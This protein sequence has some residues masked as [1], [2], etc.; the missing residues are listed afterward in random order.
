MRDTIWSSNVAQAELDSLRVQAAM[1][2]DPG[3]GYW[4]GRKSVYYADFIWERNISQAS[5]VD[6]ANGPD[7]RRVVL[8]V[9]RDGATR[10]YTY[11]TYIR[12]ARATIDGVASE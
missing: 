5:L 8:G 9:R 6:S 4:T 1:G 7:L 12:V 10:I 3:N 11:E 2:A